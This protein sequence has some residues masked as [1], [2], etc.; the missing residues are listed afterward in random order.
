MKTIESAGSSAPHPRSK[1]MILA[2]LITL[3][4]GAAL[5]GFWWLLDYE[6]TPGPRT[7]APAEWPEHSAI[8]RV[9]GTP[10]VVMFAHPLC[11]CSRASVQELGELLRRSA[12][13]EAHLLLLRP[14][15][16]GPEWDDGLLTAAKSI[17][18]LRVEKDKNGDEARRF[19]ARTSGHVVI[20]GPDGRLRFSG[21]I[22]G[23]R[24]HVGDNASLD[25]AVGALEARDS[26][27]A[28]GP[29]FGCCLEGRR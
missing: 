18:G 29:V 15:E 6:M 21:G 5:G 27:P 8:E 13:I 14:D 10:T 28:S 17:P 3:W 23:A 20:Y 19:G 4:A 16:V 22:T 1:A 7:T 12:G 11:P 24:G 26:V 9:P 25:R 2:A